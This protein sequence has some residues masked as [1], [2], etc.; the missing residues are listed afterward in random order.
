LYPRR[1][2]FE[3]TSKV[4]RASGRAVPV[5]TDK[6]LSYSWENAKWMYDTARELKIPFMAGSSLPVTWRRPP[7][8]IPLGARVTEA[9]GIGY[10]G[11]DAYGFHALEMLQCMVE[12]RTGGES[13]VA[14]VKTISGPEVWAAGDAGVWPRD[15]F[16][17]AWS[18][19]E[20][21]S[22]ESPEAAAKE[23]AAYLVEYRDGLKATILMLEGA[24]QQF[25]FAARVNGE[26]QSTLFYLQSGKPYGHFAF[27]TNKIEDLLLT[28]QPP[29]PVERTLL[30]TGILAR[31]LES[32]YRGG[33]RLA[34]PELDVEYR[35]S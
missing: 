32:R 11:L 35:V 18:R 29:Y 16:E 6:H 13:G 28:G 10:G 23:P 21:T 34:T 30:T 4:I 2:L 22:G 7:L 3:E 8:V 25:S 5:F 31:A 26:V 14:A 1:R 9:L 19:N 33:E 17:A 27:L 20:R 15:L 12:R 24:T